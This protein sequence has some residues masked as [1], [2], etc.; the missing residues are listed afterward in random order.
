MQHSLPLVIPG[1]DANLHSGAEVSKTSKKHALKALCLFSSGG[2]GELGI[3]QCGIS[4]ACASEIIPYRAALYRANFPEHEVVEGD[5]WEKGEEIFRKTKSA[6]LGSELFLVYATPP[7]QGMSS[8]GLGRLNWEVEQG[9][10]RAEDPRNRLIIPTVDLIVRLKPRWVLLENV[11]GMRFTTIRDERNKYVNIIDYIKTHL[12]SEYLGAAEVVACEDYGIP[13]KRKR[14]ITIFSRDPLAKEAFMNNGGSFVAQLTKEP[15]RTLRDAIGHL[16][17]LDARKGKNDRRDF[18]PYHYVNVLS[19]EKY[20]WIRHTPEGAT[21]LS[22]QCVNR[23]CRFSGNKAHKDEKVADKWVASKS[24]P[25]YCKKCGELLPRPVVHEKDGTVRLLKGFHSAYR[26][27]RYDEPA[28]TLTQNFIYEAS[29]NKI[30][31]TQNRVLSVLEALILQT[32]DRYGYEFRIDGRDIGIARI[33][34]VIGESV[35]PYLI[36]KICRMM[37]TTSFSNVGQRTT[38][39]RCSKRTVAASS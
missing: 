11:P 20:W 23:G 32:I 27:M 15:R 7:C 25:I 35:P 6:L 8:N 38:P 31:P 24:T 14:L 39:R 33:A 28:R 1:G 36:E 4:I 22:N 34:E 29:D 3:E 5:I 2:V 21:A 12:G 19:K 30:H 17:P 18:H 26:R 10:R 9:N 13:Q 37:I 16:P